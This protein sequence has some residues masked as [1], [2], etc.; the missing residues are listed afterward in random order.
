MTPFTDFIN[1]N[2]PVYEGFSKP[3]EHLVKVI[4]SEWFDKSNFGSG[5]IY[6]YTIPSMYQESSHKGCFEI[7]RGII[8]FVEDNYSEGTVLKL[9]VST[10][11]QSLQILDIRHENTILGN[12]FLKK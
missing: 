11:F 4:L 8:K 10:D 9:R 6:P 1:S 12:L 2:H 3:N 7:Y 5:E